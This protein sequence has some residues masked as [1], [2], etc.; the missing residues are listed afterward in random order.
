MQRLEDLSKAAK[1]FYT[2]ADAQ[3]D[4]IDYSRAQELKKGLYQDYPAEAHTMEQQL[5]MIDRISN[6]SELQASYAAENGNS[7]DGFNEWFAEQYGVTPEAKSIHDAVN[8]CIESFIKDDRTSE[9]QKEEWEDATDGQL[10]QLDRRRK[11]MGFNFIS[12]DDERLALQIYGLETL[13]KRKYKSAANMEQ[14]KKEAEKKGY[15]KIRKANSRWI[16][17][18]KRQHQRAS[19]IIEETG[20]VVDAAAEKIM[21]MPEEEVAEEVLE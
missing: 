10:V 5:M 11:R 1:F 19:R 7:L 6:I 4:I 14:V 18:G 16:R 9:E 3:E 17:R 12:I 21:G 13:I 8:A 20:E 15:K 2:V